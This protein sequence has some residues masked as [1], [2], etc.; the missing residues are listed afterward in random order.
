[1]FGA[2]MVAG[3]MQVVRLKRELI[4]AC[5]TCPLCHKLIRDATTISECLHSFCRKCILNKLSDEEADCCPICEIDLG[6]LPEEKLRPDHNLQDVR[7]KI[8]PYKKRKVNNSETIQSIV[9]PVRRKERS[10]S[11]LVVSTPRMVAHTSLTGRRTKAVARKASTVRGSTLVIDES[12]KKE[13]YNDDDGADSSSTETLSRMSHSRRL[14][15]SNIETLNHTLSKDIENSPEV[16]KS[17]LWRPLNCLVEAANRTKGLKSNLQTPT[18]K[19]EKTNGLNNGSHI[20]EHPNKIKLKDEKD[21]YI[22]TSLATV[23]SRRMQCISRKRKD[24]GPSAQAVLDVADAARERKICPVWLS[25]LSS[26]QQKG[27]LPLPQISAPYL[28]IKEGNVPVSSLQKYLVKKLNLA[29]EDEI[30]IACR[31]QLVNPTLSLHDLI[32]QWLHHGPSQ[33][34]QTSVG[35]SAK[36]FI[37]VL[38]YM[39]KTLSP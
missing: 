9:L 15:S 31:G 25:L 36:D 17:E 14:A 38:T 11:S 12:K 28:R 39:R 4:A 37:M 34:V 3:T 7:S 32:E 1:M 24:Q 21:N 27:D 5:M 22:S 35:T 2:G 30:E 20:R 29:N 23:K 18:I 10:L 6:C 16:Y 26:S 19:V 8:F 33:R 13:C